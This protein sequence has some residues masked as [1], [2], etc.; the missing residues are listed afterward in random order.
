[1]AFSFTDWQ[2]PPND[3]NFPQPLSPIPKLNANRFLTKWRGSVAIIDYI[4][5]TNYQTALAAYTPE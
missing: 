1:M 5:A 4:F 2:T 3:G